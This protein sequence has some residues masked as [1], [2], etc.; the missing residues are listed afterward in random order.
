M[1]RT[2]NY[3]R[4]PE[5]EPTGKLR[6]F[7]QYYVAQDRLN[8][9]AAAIRAGYAE[10]SAAVQATKFLKRPDCQAYIARLMA[11]RSERT[12]IDSDWVLQQLAAID[13]ME[14]LDILNPDFSL[15][16]LDQWPLA[17]RKYFG[18]LELGELAAADGD[19]AKMVRT[20]SKLKGPDK[21]KN[22]EL[23]GK[24]VDVGAFRERIEVDASNQ[25]AERMA[26]AWQRVKER[27]P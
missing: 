6:L 22:L 7:C 19:P 9:S 8:G 13:A 1:P 24:H 3:Q 17:W 14:L 23:I 27:T 20:I 26:R 4:H 2:N 12:K 18:S 10:K 5:G 25:L 11:E 15:K 16:A 21:Q